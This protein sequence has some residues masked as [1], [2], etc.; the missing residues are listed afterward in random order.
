MLTA[1]GEGA[2]D[3]VD[4][5]A[6]SGPPPP[7]QDLLHAAKRFYLKDLLNAP[8]LAR[9]REAL[10]KLPPEKRVAQTCN[11]EAIG[12]IG[13]AGG[14]FN[15]DA[16]V[17]SAFAK[18]AVN[19][20]TYSVSNGAFRSGQTW[21]VIAYECTLSKDFGAVTHFSFHIGSDVTATMQARF[22]G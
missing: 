16:L 6:A 8:A 1:E 5:A 12:Q 9:T 11:L 4:P 3:G 14:D 13:N 18:P 20:T 21:H 7:A 19:G 22:G 15:P 17:A 2:S 10:K